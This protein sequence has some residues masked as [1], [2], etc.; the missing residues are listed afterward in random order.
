[1]IVIDELPFNAIERPGFKRFCRV[2]IPKFVIL[3]KKTIVKT[4]LRMYDAKKAEKGAKEPLCVC[5]ISDTWT[6]I[7]NINYMVITD[8]FIDNG[9]RMHKRV[10]NF[11]LIPNHQGQTIGKILEC[12]LL[13]W[14]SRGS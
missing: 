7:Q 13:Q 11:C 12:C 4:F 14:E 10:L 2:A 1:M 8:P 9:W 6:S 5:L 3:C